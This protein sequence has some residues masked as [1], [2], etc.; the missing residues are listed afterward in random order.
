M[1]KIVIASNNPVK[2][3][4]TLNG[5]Q[6]MFP[7][8]KFEIKTISVSSGVNDQPKTDEE[9]LRGAYNRVENAAKLETKADYWVGIEGGI[10]ETN[11]EMAAFAW[12]VIK[13]KTLTGKS[14]SGTFFLPKNIAAMIRDGKEMGIANDILFNRK[15]S[16]QNSGAIGILTNDVVDRSQLY[17][18][19]II[20]ALV[21]FKNVGIY[22]DDGKTNE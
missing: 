17:E 2:A 12:V 10:E 7:D 14:R 4:A 15:N 19:A 8:E 6:K 13:S 1:K 21:G 20:L 11:G 5:F 9:T 22:I 3:T 18:H 16:K